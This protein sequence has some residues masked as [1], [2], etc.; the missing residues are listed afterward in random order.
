MGRRL[1]RPCVALAS[2]LGLAIPVTWGAST[3]AA[4]PLHDDAAVVRSAGH[5]AS[6]RAQCVTTNHAYDKL[7]I[8]MAHDIDSRLGGRE[9]TVGL[10]ETDSQ[11]GITC[12]Y[13]ANAHFYAASAIKVTILAALLHKAQQEDRQLTSHE[14]SLAWLMITQSDNQAATALWNDVGYADVQHFLSAAKMTETKLNYAWGLTLLTAHDEVLLLTLI[15]TAN[16]VLDKASRV[17]ERFLMAHV[18][19]SQRWGVPAGAPS[20]VIV[21]VKNGWLPYPVH[22]GPWVINSLGI[23]T[24]THRVYS[25]A[26]LTYSNPS[27]GYGI[28]TIERVAE[29]MHHDLSP[30]AHS[31]VRYSTPNASWGRSDGSV[32]GG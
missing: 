29:I 12:Q 27:M 3:A 21:H 28:E 25:M 20:D 2:V 23:F 24:N 22:H 7:A 8:T 10:D 19:S 13:N 18:I 15:S 6:L 17:Y 1:I 11:T 32:P 5:A 30:G 26:V 14:K 16:P 4:S 9:S 31:A